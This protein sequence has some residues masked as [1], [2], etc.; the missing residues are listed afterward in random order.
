MGLNV[1]EIWSRNVCEGKWKAGGVRNRLKPHERE[2]EGR[3]STPSFKVVKSQSFR[4]EQ[5][6]LI[7]PVVLEHQLAADHGKYV[8][9]HYHGVDFRA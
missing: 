9:Q 6:C 5:T 2:G 3:S 7:I 1:Q 8:F 4:L